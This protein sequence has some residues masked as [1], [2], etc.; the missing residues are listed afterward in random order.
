METGI[1]GA[2]QEETLLHG[3]GGEAL[4]CQPPAGPGALG[5]G[6]WPNS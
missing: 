5:R 2:R 4:V 1:K 6:R 3:G